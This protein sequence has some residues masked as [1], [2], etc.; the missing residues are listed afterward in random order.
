MNKKGMEF[1]VG[2]FVGLIL[3]L[4][5]F[6]AGSMIFYNIYDKATES[7]QD[8]DSRMRDQILRTFN[9]GSQLYLPQTSITK[10]S[11]RYVTVYFAVHNVNNIEKTFTV[12]VSPQ[13]PTLTTQQLPTITVAGNSREVGIILVDTQGADRGQ[14]PFVVQLKDGTDNYGS[15]RVFTINV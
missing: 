3:G 10:G 11:D 1:A 5:M 8:V 7:Q 12:E 9:D 6:I 15:A 4:A 14:Y 13:S 2:T